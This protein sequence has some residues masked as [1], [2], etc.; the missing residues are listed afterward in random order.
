MLKSIDVKVDPSTFPAGVPPHLTGGLT[1]INFQ[2]AL[3]LLGTLTVPGGYSAASTAMYWAWVRY[4][5]A[6]S[7][8]HDFRIT[9]DFANLD[10]HQ[11][12]V[13][14]DDFGVAIGTQW[15]YDRLGGFANI[16]DGR[17]FLKLYSSLAVLTTTPT[18]KVGSRKCPD[19][20]VL[21]KHGKWH[22]L[23]CKGNQ[24]GKLDDQLATAVKQKAGIRILPPH[25]G[26]S[27]AT[28]VFIAN[29]GGRKRS[30]LRVI[31]PPVDE[32]L[33]ISE[34]DSFRANL[35]LRRLA[36]SRALGLSGF[37][38]LAMQV[39]LPQRIA[40]P[41]LYTRYE[42]RATRISEERRI[43]DSIS[44][45][46]TAR[47]R[48]IPSQLGELR[49]REA[50]FD[51][52]GEAFYENTGGNAV[53]VRQGVPQELIAQIQAPRVSTLSALDEIV[54]RF[55]DGTGVV[56]TNEGKRTTV[57]DNGIFSAELEILIR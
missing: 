13:L 45:L 39:A 41:E 51:V 56:I 35:T 3:T 6:V 30:L 26:D 15:L 54:S 46:P 9:S 50:I 53:R 17:D 23:E 12:A 29:S 32:L 49:G 2:S 52:T 7:A 55:Y 48:T 28:G 11:K 16:V 18:A 22:V 44:G 27:L 37:E 4:M 34:G 43:S 5:S 25:N 40:L 36:L 38:S 10:P 19:F 47:T 21:D 8:S 24:T 42:R 33:R 57:V 20:V 31:D 1:S 14:S